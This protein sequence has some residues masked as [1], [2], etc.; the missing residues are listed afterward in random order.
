MATFDNSQSWTTDAPLSGRSITCP[1]E[2]V[3]VGT[4]LVAQVQNSRKCDN[5]EELLQYSPQNW[6]RTIAAG[7]AWFSQRTRRFDRDPIFGFVYH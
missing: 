3:N 2:L 5:R 1:S 7:L 6:M 4:P